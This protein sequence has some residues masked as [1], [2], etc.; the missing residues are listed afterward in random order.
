MSSRLHLLFLHGVGT[1]DPDDRWMVALSGSLVS[2]GYPSLDTDHLIAP[3]YAHALKGWDTKQK[4]PPTGV[5]SPA[6][7]DARRN[8][9][10]FELRT[11]ALEYRLGRTAAGRVVPGSDTVVDVAFTMP[12]FRQAHNYL[13]DP[14][15]RAQVLNLVLAALP[16]EGEIV[17]VGHSL[18]SV[19]AA[20][21]LRR[22]PERIRVVGMVT[23][24]S[25]LANGGVDVDDLR[26]MLAEPPVNLDWWVNFWNGW[27][28]VAAHRGLSSVFP[29]LLDFRVPS[30]PHVHVHDAVQYLADAIVAKAVGFAM[31][32]S[33]SREVVLT[34][35]DVDVPL[36]ET[37]KIVLL[38]L[39]YSHLVLGQLKGDVRSRY[40]GALRQVQ[41]KVVDDLIEQRQVVGAL[42]PSRLVELTF[43]P[44]DA[45]A[46]VPLPS[47]VG[48]LDK[49]HAVVS[50]TVL[51]SENVIRPFEITVPREA[52]RAA[53][54][55]LSAE[56][57]LT[58]AFGG[59][60]FRATQEAQNALSASK[61]ANWLKIGALGAGA[62]AI[63]VA[64][65]GLALAAGAGLAGAAAVTSALAA[66]GP[67]GMIGGLITAGSLVGA[68]GGGIA[69]GLAGSGTASEVVEA[70]VMRQLAAAKLRQSHGLD[71]DPGVWRGLVEME[72]LVR[73]EHERLD[74]FSDPTSPSLKDL[75]E[76]IQIL[77]RALKYLRDHGL[78]PGA[79]IRLDGAGNSDGRLP[80]V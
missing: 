42:L 57:G 46:A 19:I 67:G 34:H 39:R 31:F 11:G 71:Q 22:L 23:I 20:D 29:W 5:K 35:N 56:S 18:G 9:R 24:G 15:V 8:R 37:E 12:P 6:R 38:A 64:T 7:E 61:G 69:F 45:D 28:P 33:L 65:G 55:E 60:V 13:H 41:A 17:I 75:D 63:V 54:M 48:H 49:E 72:R 2:L 68:G 14:A 58:S 47:P 10:E 70:V 51:A 40:A 74:E 59:D 25:P 27:D 62:A 43:D 77:A 76:K 53:L 80:A 79:D 30:I 1:G 26:S 78:E 16:S 44:A 36:D 21:L 73:R 52:S 4:M 50:M 3:K 32:G 66:F